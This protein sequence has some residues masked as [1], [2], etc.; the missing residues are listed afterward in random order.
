MNIFCPEQAA[1]SAVQES[2]TTST[3]CAVM[4]AKHKG[5]R[6]TG[7]RTQLFIRA[8][9]PPRVLVYDGTMGQSTPVGDFLGERTR[10]GSCCIALAGSSNTESNPVSAYV[11][12][13]AVY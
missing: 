11:E 1:N 6:R 2:S 3:R 10:V 9:K 12:Q 7:Q 5:I 4:F 13:K 8:V